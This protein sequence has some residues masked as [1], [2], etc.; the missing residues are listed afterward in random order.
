MSFL[1]GY[2][3][4]M[5]EAEQIATRRFQAGM[6][7]QLDGLEAQY[8]RLEAEMWLAKAREQ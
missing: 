4:Q 3:R 2:V 8:I 5:Q 6:A 7:S 1:E